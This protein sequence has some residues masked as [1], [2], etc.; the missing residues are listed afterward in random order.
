MNTKTMS[1]RNAMLSMRFGVIILL[2]V[3]WQVLVTI[4]AMPSMTPAPWEVLV[5]IGTT[6]FSAHF[7]AALLQTVSASLAGWAIAAV[8]GVLL[9][10]IIG[11]LAPVERATSALIDIGRSFPMIALLPVVILFLGAN[12]RMEIFMVAISCLW[13]VLVQTIY[14]ARR[15]ESALNDTIRMFRIP[16]LL[17]FRKVMLPSA[18]PFIATGLRISA[19][20]AVLVAVSTEVLSQN[21]GLGRQITLAQETQNWDVAFAYLFF[22]GLLGWGLAAGLG[23]LENRLLAWNRRSNAS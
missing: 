20:I 10:L 19:S 23:K 12:I 2:L 18:S 4:H 9:G 3:I 22:T 1:P 15:I 17:R 14:G 6:L 21:P 11:S 13:P 8:L 16:L 7:W 5:S